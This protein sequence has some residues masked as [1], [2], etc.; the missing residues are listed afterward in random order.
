M[1]AS[2]K[3]KLRKELDADKLTEKQRSAQAEA[4][5]VNL[6]TAAFIF[7]MAV[8]LVVALVVGVRQTVVNTG[9]LA[10]RTTALTIGDQALNNVEFN[11]Y[12]MD[13]VNNFY[14][15]YGSYATMFG[16]DPTKPLNEQISDAETGKTWAD[17]FLE[18]AKTSAQAVYALNNAANAEGFTLPEA[19]QTVVDTTMNNLNAYAVLSGFPDAKAYVQAIYGKGADLDTYRAYLERT[20]LAQAYQD[21]YAQSLTYTDEDLRQAEAENFNAY[22]SYS[23]NTY[24]LAA[25]RFLTGGTKNE[26]DTVT[27]SDEEKAAAVAAAEEAAKALTGKDIN[28]VEALDA[29]IAALDINAETEAASTV[30]TNTKYSA[31]NAAYVDWL[32]DASR[33]E[34]DVAYFANTTTAEDGTETVNGYY[35][36]YFL[37]STDNAFPLSN[38]RH[39]LAAFEGGTKDETTGVTTYSDEEKAA[40]KKKAEDLLE[41]WKSGD[42][43]EDSFAALA[44][45][46]SADGDGTTGGLYENIGPDTNFVEPFKAWAT[47]EHKPGDTGIVETQYGYHV[48][49]YVGQ[50]DYTYRDYQI[51]NQLRSEDVSEWY[52]NTVEATTVTDGDTSH[53]KL[54]LVLSNGK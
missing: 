10:K 15:N 18:S 31:L 43:T 8:L 13:A 1:S 49:Y 34:G 38:V 30:Y 12:Y 41:Q 16:L 42:A 28:S 2:N 35:V 20:A 4:K 48:M 29:A 27:Y 46:S 39:I 22:S 26:D 45:E 37:S 23:Y 14:S 50:T 52:T 3:K 54:D 32:T 17:D 33:K 5:K 25:S 7:V 11:Y 36:V 24:Y 53:L 47:A 6:Y 21:H 40:A 44:N 51:E 9:F 19:D